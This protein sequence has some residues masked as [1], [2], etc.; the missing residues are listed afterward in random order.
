MTKNKTLSRD[1][2]DKAVAE[3]VTKSDEL[4]DEWQLLKTPEVSA[5]KKVHRREN[6]HTEYHIIYSVSY[7]VPTMYFRMFDLKGQLV[8]DLDDVIT[9]LVPG[10]S[11]EHMAAVKFSALTQMPHPLH[12]TPYFQVHPCETSKWMESVFKKS[13]NY[14]LSWLSVVGPIVGIRMDNLYFEQSG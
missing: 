11:A 2:F 5:V 3:F 13:Q 9:S 1:E 10:S 6:F 8:T 14:I 7:Q 12:Q 4:F